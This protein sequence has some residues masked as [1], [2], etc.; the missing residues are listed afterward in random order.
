MHGQRNIKIHI[1]NF[2]LKFVDTF[3]CWSE[4]DTYNRHLIWRR[5][6]IHAS[7]R[8]KGAFSKTRTEA[9]AIADD[10]NISRLKRQ[11]Q[12]AAQIQETEHN[13]SAFTKEV[14]WMYYSEVH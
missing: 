14:Q 1:W 13:T 2:L 4:S 11:V 12:E 7:G 9:W 10:L 8:H 3:R 5:V 6:C